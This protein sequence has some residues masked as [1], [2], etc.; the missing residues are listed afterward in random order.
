MEEYTIDNWLNGKVWYSS[1]GAQVFAQ[2]RDGSDRLVLDVRGFGELQHS[3]EG[4]EL[5]D[6]FGKFVTEAI[7]EKLLRE[8][9]SV[10]LSSEGLGRSEQF[11]CFP[12]AAGDKA[13][14]C[15]RQCY[16]CKTKPKQ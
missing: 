7:N 16:E 10:G 14:R 13:R 5:M 2:K 1:A 12:Y 4:I 8:G 6:R 11:Y 15:R 9:D 3:I